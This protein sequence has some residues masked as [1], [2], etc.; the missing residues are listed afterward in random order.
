MRPKVWGFPFAAL[1]AALASTTGAIATVAAEAEADLPSVPIRVSAITDPADEV[2]AF[3]IGVDGVPLRVTNTAAREVEVALGRPLTLQLLDP[4]SDHV[5]T[6]IVCST[7]TGIDAVRTYGDLDLA[8]GRVTFDDPPSNLA[9]C[10][11][12]FSAAAIARTVTLAVEADPA[13]PAATVSV[14]TDARE[15]IE[16][17]EIASGTP[18]TFAV[19][20]DE[21]FRLWSAAPAAPYAIDALA[22]LDQDGRGVGFVTTSGKSLPPG[23]LP[24]G[25]AALAAAPGSDITCTYRLLEATALRGGAIVRVVTEPPDTGPRFRFTIDGAPADI[26]MGDPYVLAPNAAE[27]TTVE[28]VDAGP[29][30]VLSAVE[31]ARGD[32]SEV[33]PIEADPAGHVAVALEP[34]DIVTCSY[35]LQHLPSVP[36]RVSAI[37]DPADEVAAFDIGV[38]GVPLR[39]TNTAAREVEVALGRP[40]TLQLLDPPSDH[41]LT[42]IVCSTRTGIDA[43]RTYGDLDLATGRVTFDDPPS[44]LAGCGFRFSA[45]AIARTVTLAVEADPADPAATVSVVTDAREPIEPVEI[46][47]GTPRTFAVPADETFR[48]WSAAPAAPYAIDALACLDQDGRGVGFVTTS[49]KSLPPGALPDGPAALAAAPGSDITCTYRLLEATAD[50]VSP[51]AGED[52]VSLTVAVGGILT[53]DDPPLVTPMPADEGPFGLEIDGQ[54]VVIAADERITRGSLPPGPITISVAD[55]GGLVFDS[56]L[57]TNSASG[58]GSDLRAADAIVTYTLPPGSETSCLLYFREPGTESAPATDKDEAAMTAQPTTEAEVTVQPRSPVPREGRWRARNGRGL[59]ACGGFSQ[60]IP[61]G[62]S[63]AGTITLRRGGDR[64]ILR[65]LS[66]GTTRPI[67]VDRVAGNPER[68]VGKQ[69]LTI[70]GV[71]ANFTFTLDLESPKRIKGRT[72]ARVRVQGQRCTITRPFTLTFEG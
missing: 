28:L 30:H 18:R 38:D 37:T 49:G 44:N 47:S 11:F 14:V 71:R 43:V 59:I 12:R 48:L 53:N 4:P 35:R 31:C 62:D 63:G 56:A 13:D 15:P 7:R 41:V 58:S 3:D 69:A 1:L 26:G 55:P 25:P 54:A 40:L 10:G 66:A 52:E 21:T 68:W 29:D 27:R 64:L 24:D 17:V 36:I 34:A 70:Q 22:C 67:R 45:A 20:A 32:G 39:V 61:A 16:P 9:G 2:A 19:P 5:L 46:A 50:V 51:V 60:T 6:D 42:D 8:T 72:E 33:T 57:C 23:A 65:D